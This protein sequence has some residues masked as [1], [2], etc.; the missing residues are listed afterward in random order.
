MTSQFADSGRGGKLPQYCRCGAL[1][2]G[3]HARSPK[4]R[5]AKIGRIPRAI[6][7]ARL[8]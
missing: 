5:G 3:K 6:A 2:V 1:W 4:N 7:P 8:L